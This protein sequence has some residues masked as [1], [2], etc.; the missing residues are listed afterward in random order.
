MVAF[1][2]LITAGVPFVRIVSCNPLEVPGPDIPPAFSGLPDRTTASQWA[3][4]PRRVR[5]DAPRDVGR[6][7]RTGCAEQGAPPLPDLEFIHDGARQPVRLPG[8]RRLHRRAAARRRPGTGSTPR[9]ARPTRPFELPA[10]LADRPD[11]SAL[12]YFSLGSLGLAPT[13]S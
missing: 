2:A 10:A 6:V 9:C 4:V 12:I 1:P 3:D 5:P 13:S 8:G 11:G 7:Q